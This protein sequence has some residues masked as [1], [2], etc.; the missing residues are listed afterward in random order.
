MF[1]GIFVSMTELPARGQSKIPQ[2]PAQDWECN[3]LAYGK[4]DSDALSAAVFRYQGQSSSDRFARA[5]DFD[6]LCTN[7]D[8][9]TFGS[10]FS[11]HRLE[12]LSSAG[13]HQSG[14]HHNF[15]WTDGE[16]DVFEFPTSRQ[17]LKFQKRN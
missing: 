9:A 15:A 17:V 14:N 4:D 5:P 10:P 13:A 11:E 7:S 8:L 16:A 12:Q 2:E 3:I 1:F 6:W